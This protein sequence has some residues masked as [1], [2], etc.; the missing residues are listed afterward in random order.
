MVKRMNSQNDTIDDIEKLIFAFYDGEITNENEIELMSV[1]SKNE[2]ARSLFKFHL[3]LKH[4]TN[5]LN[6]KIYFPKKLENNLRQ[7][8]P[9]KSKKERQPVQAISG[10][11]QRQFLITPLKAASILIF[12]FLS[13]VFFAKLTLP[14]K[15]NQASTVITGD[16]ANIKKLREHIKKV[17][18]TGND[19]I[20]FKKKEM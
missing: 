5:T 8:S 9:I 12:V 20:N 14:V 13:A 1:L 3:G 4:T 17:K 10:F 6:S 7:P 15:P 2:S 19:Q 11:W 16:M 18:I